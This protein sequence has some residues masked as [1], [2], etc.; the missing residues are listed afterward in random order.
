M[1][2]TNIPIL[3]QAE[4]DEGLTKTLEPFGRILDLCLFKEAN[5]DWFLGR[6]YVYLEF[7]TKD[8]RKAKSLTHI[9]PWNDN[10]CVIYGTWQRMGVYCRYCHEKGHVRADCPKRR[11]IRCYNCHGLGHI[12]AHCPRGVNPMVH[13]RARVDQR[14]A[15]IPISNPIFDSSNETNH[16][17]SPRVENASLADTSGDSE[18]LE[19]SSQFLDTSHHTDE[20]SLL[21]TLDNFP[22]NTQNTSN[23]VSSG[24]SPDVDMEAASQQD[25]THADSP[26]S[27]Q[28][29]SSLLPVSSDET[30][31]VSP[32]PDGNHS[33]PIEPSKQ[34][35]LK[36][37]KKKLTTATASS[38][39]SGPIS[40][41][42][43]KPG[44]G[45]NR[46]H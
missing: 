18:L 3:P 22:H 36:I 41:R 14:L 33:E 44:R 8:E 25:Q 19:S 40:G 10:E 32:V 24:T 2:L 43:A 5:G 17:P 11:Q 31:P 42:V 37:N 6:G 23:T 12:K 27:S 7:P 13:K 30:G 29:P 45:S 21:M 28:E 20:I 38:K 1:N 39:E 15:T 34:L 4:V 9:I 46:K 16:T 35:L 26:P